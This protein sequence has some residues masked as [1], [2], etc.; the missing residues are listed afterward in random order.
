MLLKI[1][2][3]LKCG[4]SIRINDIMYRENI[5]STITFYK[6]KSFNDDSV[7][8]FIQIFM[9]NLLL[10]C[11]VSSNEDYVLIKESKLLD[12]TIR[13]AEKYDYPKKKINP[14]QRVQ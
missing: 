5:V 3:D 7:S 6:Y 8:L 9:G 14:L 2:G 13:K 10:G 11:I 12:Y 4:S 1:W